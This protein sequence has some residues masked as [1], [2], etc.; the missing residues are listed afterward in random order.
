MKRFLH[1]AFL[2]LLPLLFG[3]CRRDP[4]IEALLD[5]AA[6][7]RRSGQYEEEMRSYTRALQ[8]AERIAEDSLR[9]RQLARIQ[10]TLSQRYHEQNDP[11][12]EFA[13]IE[14]SIAHAEACRDEE[15]II[16]S[17][18]M[19]A[20]HLTSKDQAAA[21]EVLQPL[22]EMRE[23]LALH[24]PETAALISLINIHLHARLGDWEAD[25]LQSELSALTPE[26]AAAYDRWSVTESDDRTAPAYPDIVAMEVF[27][28]ADRVDSAARRLDRIKARIREHDHDNMGLLAYE[29]A[30]LEAQGRFEEACAIQARYIE[31]FDSI[32]TRQAEVKLNKMAEI[33]RVEHAAALREQRLRY[34]TGIALLALLLVAAAAVGGWVNR[35]RKLRERDARIDEQLALLESLRSSH[36]SLTDR[37]EAQNE[38]EAELK[39]LLSRRF[40]AIRELAA[41]CYT[42]DDGGRLMARVKALALNAETLNDLVEMVDR[43][44][45]GVVTRL[46]AAFP[47]WTAGSIAYAALLAAGCTPQE[48]CILLDKSL[49]SVYVQKSKLRRRIVESDAPDRERLLSELHMERP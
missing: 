12:S 9:H 28:L 30:V 7:Q 41:T 38:R 31:T 19:Y 47:N 27:L 17:R 23:S 5:R 33:Y 32:R 26:Q 8:A 1:P 40:V 2:L 45:D 49:N 6:L 39:R 42:Y 43:E 37:L 3:G 21:V 29:A 16:A 34:R 22:V 15:Q 46:R 18:M 35:Q 4:T 14:Q 36:E 24:R 11:E 13:A 10:F 48:I 20:Q 25:R 44:Y